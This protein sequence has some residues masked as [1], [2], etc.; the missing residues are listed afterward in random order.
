M[1]DEPKVKR[2]CHG[3]RKAGGPCRANPVR[4]GTVVAGVALSGKWCRRHD[5]DLP[6]WAR[7][8]SHAQVRAAGALGGRP[9]MPKPTDIARQLIERHVYTV[10][11]PHFKTIGLDLHDDGSVTRLDHGAIVCGESKDGDIVP[12]EIEDLGA[13][14]A[15][16]EK[17]LDRVYGR[18]KQTQE[19][20]GADGGPLEI[21]PVSNDR[22]D[23]VAVLLA[24]TR[25]VPAP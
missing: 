4:Q 3:E 21:V 16:A 20:T 10:L 22:G 14:I 17:L 18:P 12:S 2:V 15:A 9:A 19:V 1:S 7:F 6:E 24:G 23:A 8:G 11:A 13:Q 25:A 5:P